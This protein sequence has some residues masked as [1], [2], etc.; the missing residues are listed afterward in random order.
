MNNLAL[1]KIQKI[2]YYGQPLAKRRNFDGLLLD[3]NEKTSKTDL[4]ILRAIIKCLS[5]DSLRV[6]PE[7]DGLNE[8]IAKYVGVS[9]ENI[10]TVNGTDQGIDLIFRTFTDK[11]E[12]I[13]PLPS[14]SMFTQWSNIAGNKIVSPIYDKETM[15]FPLA[16]VLKSINKRTKLIVICNP[17]NPTGTLLLINQ[18]ATIAKRAKNAIVYVDEAYFEFSKISAVGLLKRFPNII[19]SRTFS[20]AFGLG[21]LRI[22]Y[23]IARPKYIQEMLKVRG[24]YDVN[25]V[26]YFG[27]MSALKNLS[28]TNRY[29][30][31]V[32]NKARPLVES[33]FREN[34][35]K[36]FPSVSNFILVNPDNS[37]RVFEI[38]KE[39]GILV[40]YQKQAP[41]AGMLR[42]TI[43]TV[44]QMKKF[45]S[46]Y[47]NK[48]LTQKYAFIDRDGTI[49]FEPQDT[50]QID[51]VAQLKILPGVVVGLQQLLR[52]DYKLIMISNQDGLGT[53]SY[54]EKNF[55]EVQNKL[56]SVL[57]QNGIVFEK[58]FVCPHFEQDGCLCRKPKLGLVK[59]FLVKN[60]IDLEKSFVC[61]DRKSDRD[62]SRNIKVRFVSMKTNG[63][64][65]K[66]LNKLYDKKTSNV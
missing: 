39:N 21:G 22:G 60:K 63:N 15:A 61:G 46:V 36:Y 30:D 47:M 37:K 65:I 29:I 54:P 13:I 6:Y 34:N 23:L 40:R 45:I 25:M 59:V 8:R 4:N 62:F 18:I 1:E 35:I 32:V 26:A 66:S 2:G 27:A 33:F 41:I 14:F 7:Y 38:L 12:V 52:S 17:N 44:E 28:G 19:I 55:D 58:V 43:G 31:K 42:I 3:F 5:G 56:M 49:I 16:D 57:K 11:D 53:K 9:S 50:F 24:P 64:F 20:K 51:S 10:M 48:I